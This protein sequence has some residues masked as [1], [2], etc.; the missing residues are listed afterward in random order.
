MNIAQINQV[1]Q[2]TVRSLGE[3]KGTPAWGDVAGQ[4]L[5]KKGKAI[6]K[7]L[8]GS[9]FKEDVKLDEAKF[10]AGDKVLAGS[11]RGTIEDISNGKY[12]VRY[13]N[14]NFAWLRLNQ[15]RP[16][17]KGEATRWKAPKFEDV[18]LDEAKKSYHVRVK[19]Y[20]RGIG[21]LGRVVKANS[22]KEAIKIGAKIMKKKPS[23]L[24]AQLVE[25]EDGELDE[26]VAA[27]ILAASA[28][29]ILNWLEKNTSSD[30]E[31]DVRKVVR[32][33]SIEFQGV[34]SLEL[35]FVARDWSR[36]YGR[37][38]S[39]WWTINIIYPVGLKEMAVIYETP[40]SKKTQRYKVSKDALG[41]PKKMFRM[42]P[43]PLKEGVE[44]SELDEA[45]WDKHRPPSERKRSVAYDLRTV[46]PSSLKSR[47]MNQNIGSGQELD[48]YLAGVLKKDYKEW[49]RYFDRISLMAKHNP[50]LKNA[51]AQASV[52]DM[53]FKGVMRSMKTKDWRSLGLRLNDA[54][55]A[56]YNIKESVSMDNNGE[57]NLEAIR[58][59]RDHLLGTY[60]EDDFDEYDEAC[61]TPG[62]RL[63]SKGKGRGLAKGKGKGPLG[64]PVKGKDSEDGEMQDE[65]CKTPGLKLR[66]SGKG[67]GLARGNGK[68]PL[69]VPVGVKGVEG[70]GDEVSGT[71]C[72][73][74]GLKLRSRGLGRGL[75]RG[76]GRGLLGAPNRGRGLGE[77]LWS[78]EVKTKW[79]PPEGFFKQ[80]AD[81]IASGLLKASKD[82]KQA[83]S[84][85][86]FYINR[87]GENLSGEDMKRLDAAK[88]KLQQEDVE[89]GEAKKGGVVAHVRM[90]LKMFEKGAS[91]RQILSALQREGATKEQAD[92][93]L[94]RAKLQREDVELEEA[95]S[96]KDVAKGMRKKGYSYILL[97]PGKDALYA[98][99]LALASELMRTDLKNYK[100][101]HVKKIDAFLKEDVELDEEFRQGQRVKTPLGKGSVVY[102]RMGPPNYNKPVAV[103]VLL[104]KKSHM[105]SY[106]G[107][108]FKA[109]DVKPL[110]EDVELEALKAKHRV[111][112]KGRA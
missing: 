63:R 33:R 97:V 73:T 75:A 87:A 70:Y 106:T 15:I 44:L 58:A 93:Y 96:E 108:M 2:E 50:R 21:D 52:A 80:S 95:K 14:G 39:K 1:L 78:G 86:N 105:G 110:K 82:L 101:I 32:I 43:F 99:T 111:Q 68:G 92:F 55:L 47:I 18:E 38:G 53:A 26:A 11:V 81:K 66:S 27:K 88:K 94:K 22:E 36:A 16:M 49:S 65:A 56:L 57:S 109:K 90:I 19:K 61:K 12:G 107:T 28:L 9:Y 45:S 5:T 77:A 69:G 51:L 112:G 24:D 40:S 79:H 37:P 83:M 72:E 31:W 62:L 100:N 8:F 46:F 7:I 30:L 20:F 89:L 4:R 10:Q 29:K 17:G 59:M 98:K 85:L 67:R 60:E 91:D 104:D 54:E 23:Y 35:T 64:V 42:S 48:P 6:A 41:D 3:F 102:Q 71:E 76:R 25:A 34:P 74:P 84:R 13:E 103:S